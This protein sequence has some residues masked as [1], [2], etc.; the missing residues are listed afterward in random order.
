MAVGRPD[1]GFRQ[2]GRSTEE[3]LP[4]RSFTVGGLVDSALLQNRYD[5]IDKILQSLWRHDAAEIETVDS[6][7]FDPALQLVGY[8]LRRAHE[9]PGAAAEPH[10]AKQFSQRPLLT[11]ARGQRFQDRLHG[12]GLLVPERRVEIFLRVVDADGT[13]EV[14]KRPFDAAVGFVFGEFLFCFLSGTPY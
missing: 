9:W 12:I 13:R 6:G 3:L 7:F 2:T 4:Q 1:V 14:R 11:A 8:F 5:K 10:L